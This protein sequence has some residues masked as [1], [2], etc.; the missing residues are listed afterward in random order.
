MGDEDRLS[1]FKFNS[2]PSMLLTLTSMDKN[3]KEEALG[4]I[5]KLV[6]SGGT[7]IYKALEEGFNII[8]NIDYS[9][10]SRFPTIIR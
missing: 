5:G 1:I 9:S 7:N 8:K 6:A 10:I 4:T 3:G 2:N